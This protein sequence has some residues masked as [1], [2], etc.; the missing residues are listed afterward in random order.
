MGWVPTSAHQ[1][2]L[3][4]A[5]WDG[6]RRS[7]IHLSSTRARSFLEQLLNLGGKNTSNG[8]LRD[9]RNDG[10]RDLLLRKHGYDDDFDETT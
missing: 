4:V 9:Q 7:F 8:I 10:I 2:A 1:A 3:D 6:N 5:E